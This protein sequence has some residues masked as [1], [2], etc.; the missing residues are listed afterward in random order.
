M[1]RS[2]ERL[3]RVDPGFVRPEQ[4]QTFRVAIP[5]A[6]NKQDYWFRTEFTPPAS[7]KRRPYIS[8]E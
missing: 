2:F 6:L 7:A 4:V 5:E 3:Q 1:L 8:M